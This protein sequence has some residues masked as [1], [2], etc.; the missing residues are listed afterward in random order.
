MGYAVKHRWVK[1]FSRWDQQNA[2][3][4]VNRLWIDVDSGG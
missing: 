4:P 2:K 3:T 1:G